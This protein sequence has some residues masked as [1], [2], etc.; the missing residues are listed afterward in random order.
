MAEVR[1][2]T[3]PEWMLS[4][5][6]AMDENR[7][8]AVFEVAYSWAHVYIVSMFLGFLI[9][10]ITCG[11]ALVVLAVLTERH[12]RVVSNYLILSL[13]MA[14]LL[15][16][17]VVMPLSLVH[18]V[19]KVW[20]LG[21]PLCDLW[22]CADVLLCTVSTLHLCA[23]AIERCLA[24]SSLAYLR[25]RSATFVLIMVG[26]CWILATMVSLPARFHA[27]RQLEIPNV[28]YEGVCEINMEEGYTIY[29]NLLAF[30][31]PMV[32]IVLMY[33]RIYFTARRH[34][35]KKHFIKY[36]T[37][38]ITK[39]G[40]SCQSAAS[41]EG[42]EGHRYHCYCCGYVMETKFH[43]GRT[44]FKVDT[45]RCS[46][47]QCSSSSDKVTVTT[48]PPKTI[49]AAAV[50]AMRMAATMIGTT[51]EPE[52]GNYDFEIS[53]SEETFNVNPFNPLKNSNFD[54]ESQIHESFQMNC[55]PLTYDVL[56]SLQKQ[57]EL[58]SNREVVAPSSGKGMVRELS[59][60]TNR[61]SILYAD[62][63]S[64]PNSLSSSLYSS[65]IHAS[66]SRE[67]ENRNTTEEHQLR[68]FV[69]LYIYNKKRRQRRWLAQGRIF[70][71]KA[72]EVMKNLSVSEPDSGIR[73]EEERYVRER[74]E[75][76]RERRTVRTLAIIT[77]CFV[78]CWLPFNINALLS[79]FFGRIHPIGTSVL[80]WLGY[81][82]SLLNPIIYTIFSRDF[83][84]AFRRIICQG[85]RLRCFH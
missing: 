3:A 47:I 16:A 9:I 13:A 48:E 85:P 21:L 36:Q 40:N 70:N 54:D 82:N 73:P 29:S 81:L 67:I 72:S 76:K 53:D 62:E 57:K 41:V 75:Q 39:K 55:Q 58:T 49:V 1:I 32:F 74:L 60:Y 64:K 18:E 83:R 84:S 43:K 8:I 52:L 44:M 59:I 65:M 30:D 5:A 66:D 28:V 63:N 79:P 37:T 25:H 56:R 31:L 10:C 50:T 24:V 11:N 4:S 2:T 22:I 35:R 7:T 71:K 20:W 14:D 23:I 33:A 38:S 69:P 51:K 19:S 46:E 68:N 61:S 15:V 27:K 26:I 34:I 45:T 6:A 80:L 77:G 12:L 17:V 42:S 78:L